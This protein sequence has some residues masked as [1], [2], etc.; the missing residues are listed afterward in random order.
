MPEN[1]S[2]HS[3]ASRWEL[4]RDIAVFQLKV[5]VDALRDL[6]LV[7]VSLVAG[8]LDL[9]RGGERPGKLFYDVLDA[10]RRTENW[11]NLFG[12]LDGRRSVQTTGEPDEPLIDSVDARL[13]NLIVEQYEQGGMTAA[14]K[15][16]IDRSLDALSTAKN[17]TRE[18]PSGEQPDR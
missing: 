16:A 5:G 18:I 13:E 4:I 8:A 3:G 2:P 7:P 9:I 10:G 14:A 6:A 15:D 12:D 1:R 11:I 17:T